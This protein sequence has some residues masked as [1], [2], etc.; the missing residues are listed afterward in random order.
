MTRQIRE[1]RVDGGLDAVG[2]IAREE[3]REDVVQEIRGER[4]VEG[5]GDGPHP[6]PV[7]LA[8]SVEPEVRERRLVGLEQFGLAGGQFEVDGIDQGLT[9]RPAN[10]AFRRS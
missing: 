1:Q 2:G 4:R 8:D 5:R 9:G 3:L 10:S 6:H 7:A